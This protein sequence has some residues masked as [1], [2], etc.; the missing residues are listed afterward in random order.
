[1][2]DQSNNNEVLKTANLSV[3][4]ESREGFLVARIVGRLDGQNAQQFKQAI[5]SLSS[6]DHAA[7]LLDMTDLTYINSDGLRVL[8]GFRT[9]LAKNSSQLRLCNLSDNIR[10]V[11]EISG[12]HRVI[13]IYAD[14]AAGMQGAS[15]RD[16]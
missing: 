3:F 16:P 10:A 11:F 4:A 5:T 1:M 14:L 7:C 9:S 6:S 2:A 13:P 15:P 8:L 12:F